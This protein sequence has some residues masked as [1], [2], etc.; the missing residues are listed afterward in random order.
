MS[1]AAALHRW[2]C[3]CQTPGVLLATWSDDGRVNIKVRDR[4]WHVSG[5]GVIETVCPRCATEHRLVLDDLSGDPWLP[6]TD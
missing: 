5:G 4:Y 1:A 3:A 2:E 6:S